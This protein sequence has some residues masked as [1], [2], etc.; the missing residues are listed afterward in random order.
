MAGIYILATLQY[1]TLF[2][3]KCLVYHGYLLLNLAADRIKHGATDG[4]LI[5]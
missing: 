3:N 1:P 5:P 2:Y 4:H